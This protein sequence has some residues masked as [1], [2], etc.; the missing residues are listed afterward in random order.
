ML[1]RT[2]IGNILSMSKGLEYVVTEQIRAEVDVKPVSTT[3]KGVSMIGFMGTFSINFY[4]PDYLGIGKSVSRGFG[5]V[6][7]MSG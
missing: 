6:T 5:T 4:I 1:D 2:L 3:L 7:A